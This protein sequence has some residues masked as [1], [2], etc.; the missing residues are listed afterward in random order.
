MSAFGKKTSKMFGGFM[1]GRG[2][3]GSKAVEKIVVQISMHGSITDSGHGG[4]MNA[5]SKPSSLCLN[6]LRTIIDEAFKV[7]NVAAVVLSINC[8]SGSPVQCSILSKYLR[9]MAN[10]TG[11]PLLAM[12]EDAAICNGYWLAGATD[13]IFADQNAMI[14]SIGSIRSTATCTNS[15]SNM[16]WSRTLLPPTQTR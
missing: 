6:S 14:G 10:N 3:S 8:S 1:D 9:E 11:V 15:Y 13:V 12:V 4:G 7:N 16:R 2:S 5:L